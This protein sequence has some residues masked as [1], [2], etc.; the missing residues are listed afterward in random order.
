MEFFFAA[1]NK[2]VIWPLIEKESMLYYE[3]KKM[4]CKRKYVQET[5]FNIDVY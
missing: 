4:Q 1:I 2:H 3:V 5:Q